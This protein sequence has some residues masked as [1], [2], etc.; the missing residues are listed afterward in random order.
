MNNIK[1]YT[2]IHLRLNQT[3]VLE[4]VK[5]LMTYLVLYVFQEYVFQIT[6]KI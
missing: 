6:L 3:N 2:T 5:L 4:V 1:N